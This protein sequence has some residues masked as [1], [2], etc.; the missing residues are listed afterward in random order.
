M[1]ELG[2]RNVHGVWG[3]SSPMIVVLWVRL[4]VERKKKRSGRKPAADTR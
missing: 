1:I 3:V 4:D 2:G